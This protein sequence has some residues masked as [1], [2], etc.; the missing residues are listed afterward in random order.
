MQQILLLKHKFPSLNEYTGQNRGNKFV[1]ASLKKKFTN[2]VAWE[3]KAQSL[4]QF[5]KQVEL[6]ITW[7][8]KTKRRDKDNIAFSIKF[9][10]DG[11]VKAGVLKNDNWKWVKGFNHNFEV[12]NSYGVKVVIKEVEQ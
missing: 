1:G 7:C 4:R 3:C 10:L 5:N 12:G 6:N 11:L 9:I 2:L 8:E